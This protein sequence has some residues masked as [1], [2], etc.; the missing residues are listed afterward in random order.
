VQLLTAPVFFNRSEDAS[1]NQP[2]IRR[3][4]VD[5]AAS[6][7]IAS[8]TIPSISDA[9]GRLLELRRLVESSLPAVEL[10]GDVETMRAI[11][12]ELGL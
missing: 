3:S 10:F 4:T 7:E 5:I 2:D 8:Q 12:L 9:S 6:V 1:M 11:R